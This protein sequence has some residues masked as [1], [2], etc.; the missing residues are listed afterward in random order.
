M[1]CMYMRP[2]CIQSVNFM[3]SLCPYF[4]AYNMVF[5]NESAALRYIS[6]YNQ[7][8]KTFFS[9]MFI[10]TIYLYIHLLMTISCRNSLFTL[11]NSMPVNPLLYL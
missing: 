3:H 4:V 8:T 10:I 6:K 11:V 2:C 5:L 9:F 1:N 7:F